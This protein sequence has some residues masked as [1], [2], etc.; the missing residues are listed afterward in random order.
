MLCPECGGKSRVAETRSDEYSIY[1]RRECKVCNHRF[2]TYEFTPMELTE[3]F[4]QHFEKNTVYKLANVI[5]T[6]MPEGRGSV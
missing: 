4:E 1:R 2:T 5:S 3:L 6:V